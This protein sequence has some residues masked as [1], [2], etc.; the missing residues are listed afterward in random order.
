M[1]TYTVGVLGHPDLVEILREEG[2]EVITGDDPKA[3][4]G[5]IKSAFGGGHFPVVVEDSDDPAVSR[6]AAGVARASS[7]PVAVLSEQCDHITDESIVHI[8]LPAPVFEIADRLGISV[9][10]QRWYPSEAE[11]DDEEEG[12]DLG[13]IPDF[14]APDD[15]DSG[16]QPSSRGEIEWDSTRTPATTPDRKPGENTNG[17]HRQQQPVRQRQPVAVGANEASGIEWDSTGSSPP[18]P[19]LAAPEPA[20]NAPQTVSVAEPEGQPEQGSDYNPHRDGLVA[21]EDSAQKATEDL[22]NTPLRRNLAPVI[23]SFSGKGGVS[24]ALALDTPI[25]TPSG[26]TTMGEVQAGT[27]LLGRDGHPT[28]VTAT[29]DHQDLVLYD[30]HFSDGQIVRACADH[31]WAVTGYY[32]RLNRIHSKRYRAMERYDRLSD[33]ATLLDELARSYGR[34]KVTRRQIYRLVTD[35]PG[36]EWD[37]EK[38]LMVRLQDCPADGGE[39]SRPKEYIASEAFMHLADYIRSTMPDQRPT[40][41]ARERVLTTQQMIDQGT[42][43][44]LKGKPT[45]NFAVRTIEAL[46]L[47][48]ADLPLDPYVLGAWLG[49]GTEEGGGFTSP[50]AEVLDR[51]EDC[52]FDVAR[53]SLNKE[54]DPKTWCSHYIHNLRG[55]LREVGVLDDKHIPAS[56]LRASKRQRMELLAGLLDSDGSIAETGVISLGLSDERLATD[57]LELIRT[58]GIRVQM[59]TRQAGYRNDDGD[60]IRCKDSH[61]MCFTTDLPVFHLP[62]KAQRLPEPGNL[63]STQEWIYITDIIEAG[64]GPGRCL[65]VDNDESL[66]LC[67]GFLPTHNTS[68][69]IQVATTAAAA[70]LRV[71]LVDGNRAQADIGTFLGVQRK[72]AADM[73]TI[74][75][76]LDTGDAKA[77]VVTADQIMAMRPDEAKPLPEGMGVIFGADSNDER[78]S[79]VGPHTYMSAIEE[80]R[81]RV[82]LVVVDTQIIEADDKS[83]MVEGMVIPLLSGPGGF[84]IGLTDV[85][86]AGLSNLSKRINLLAEAGVERN[87]IMI[88]FNMALPDS[89]DAMEDMGYQKFHNR[90]GVFLGVIGR[91]HRIEEYMKQG[92]VDLG[93]TE[94]DYV[95]NEALLRAT[96]RPEFDRVIQR[97]RSKTRKRSKTDTGTKQPKSKPGLFARMLGRR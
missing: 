33:F 62:R 2:V 8:G 1:S 47:P 22:F 57:A 45:T 66:F 54:S 35:H 87:R 14:E 19:S 88:A 61:Q 21:A 81:T 48:E 25:P 52:G 96:N 60:Y 23:T 12:A 53:G 93:N 15:A 37:K 17:T 79:E 80:I 67:A 97:R 72:Y 74:A 10:S 29:Y 46:D 78:L 70:G 84:G 39:G 51:I 49:D 63:R 59:R 28:R 20:E 31:R 76:Y 3:A 55:P 6:W 43:V 26:W 82:D 69:S 36:C 24:K 4:A 42:K 85:E 89:V 16:D 75:D 50:D 41:E 73:P 77:T 13:E 58:L 68:T 30:V 65:T 5:A 90:L 34:Q 18:A 91:D 32:D 44:R 92:R 71:V 86:R 7:E 56:Y 38:S 11:A 27:Q 64:T 95:V 83:G 9:D 40:T 94:Y